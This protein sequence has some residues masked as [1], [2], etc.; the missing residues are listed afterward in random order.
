[1]LSSAATAVGAPASAPSPAAS[2]GCANSDASPVRSG[3][4]SITRCRTF[5]MI[6]RGLSTLPVMLAGQAAVQRPHSVQV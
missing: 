4:F 5:T 6:L 3:A 1:L 2:A